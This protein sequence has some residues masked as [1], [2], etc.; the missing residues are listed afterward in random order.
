MG[1]SR[2]GLIAGTIAM[3]ISAIL[4]GII[5]YITEYQISYMAIG[6]G[7]FVG[8]AIQKFGKG[9]TLIYG[10]SG[11][12]LSIMGCLLGNFFFYNGILAREWGESFFNVL[13]AISLNPAVI[14]EIFILGFEI[15]DLLFY[16][17]AAYLGFQAAMKK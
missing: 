8:I 12:I 4:W 5:T 14:I 1:D 7:F 6:V 16:G 17:L 3:L 11:A 15:I 10:I 13:F 2:V 9:N